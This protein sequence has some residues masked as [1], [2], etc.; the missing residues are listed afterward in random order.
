MRAIVRSLFFKIFVSFWIAMT[1]IS[2]GFA[3]IYA[4]TSTEARWE[5]WQSLH[6]DAFRL[7]VR[8]ELDKL[9]PNDA[10]AV[11]RLIESMSKRDALLH[12]FVV[13]ED[14]PPRSDIPLAAQN[15]G[16]KALAAGKALQERGDSIS[17]FAELLGPRFPKLALVEELSRPSPVLGYIGPDTLPFRLLVILAVSG[18]VCYG[19]A[20][21]LTRRLLEIRRASRRLA[22][23]DLAVRIEPQL[24]ELDD[25]A[26]ALARDLD[27][28]AE[29][30]DA[31]LG[32]QQRL[33]R[34]VS[35]ELRSPLARLTIALELAR[36][37]A[38]GEVGEYHDRI[39]READLLGQLIGEILTL[40]RLEGEAKAQR[41]ADALDLS[42]LV[43]EVAEDADFEARP[44]QRR[45]EVI[46]GD[47]IT[48]LG[49]AE[50]LRRAVENVVRN[51]VRF[52]P[53]ESSVE[54]RLERALVEGRP[55][56]R[57]DVRDRG[58]GVPEGYLQEIFQ[59][60]FRVSE[61]RDRRSGGTGVG[62]AITE[63]A[64]RLHGGSVMAR[65]ADGGG[66]I[67][68]IALPLGSVDAA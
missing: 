28:M 6:F 33:L 18:L 24:G 66:L 63:R 4:T 12:F 57:L 51:A 26:T 37:E 43:R 42:E 59:P 47:R 52:A 68:S 34:D 65:N 67:V 61:S 16:G 15:L 2:A 14:E 23:G 55:M 20:R 5:R 50:I 44:S 32:A 7:R 19:L 48:L 35:H 9:G 46:S 3:L 56:A 30:I 41:Q 17:Y 39:A 54:V 8:E 31:L 53:V 22:E 11:P 1:L 13:T 62:L 25:E 45:V 60:F 58:P 29:R 49:Y 40:T 27:Q 64:V 10:D 21:Q 38:K 36:Q